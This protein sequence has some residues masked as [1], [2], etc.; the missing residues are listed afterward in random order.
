MFSMVH[1]SILPWFTMIYHGLPVYFYKGEQE[2][3]NEQIVNNL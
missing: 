3:K 1:H 2:E